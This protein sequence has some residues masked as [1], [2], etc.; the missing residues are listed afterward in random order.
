MYSYVSFWNIPRT[1]WGEMQKADA[2]DQDILQKALASGTL[3]GYGND[4]SLVHQPDGFTH[5]EWWSSM[6][7]AGLM[8]VLEA[9]YKSGS[10]A[11]PVLAELDQTR[12]CHHGEPVLQLA[13]RVGERRVHAR[14]VLQIEGGCAG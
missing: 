10:A 1:Q 9:F 3:V 6:S 11:S 4:V 13:F 7:M 5:D 2:T 12:R 14:G 8:H